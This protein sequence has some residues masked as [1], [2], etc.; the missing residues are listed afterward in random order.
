[1]LSTTNY[2]IDEKHQVYNMKK[3][4]AEN[5]TLSQLDIMPQESTLV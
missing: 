2:I 1:M 4:S 5:K 3:K